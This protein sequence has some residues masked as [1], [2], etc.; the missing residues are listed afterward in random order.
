MSAFYDK[1]DEGP[2]AFYYILLK[3]NEKFYNLIS[4]MK[5][6]NIIYIVDNFILIK[7]DNLFDLVGNEYYIEYFPVNSK[8]GEILNPL[9]ENKLISYINIITNNLKKRQN[10]LFTTDIDNSYTVTHFDKFEKQIHFSKTYDLGL[11]RL[12]AEI[13]KNKLKLSSNKNILLEANGICREIL[14][15]EK[16]IIL[17]KLFIQEQIVGEAYRQ[18]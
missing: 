8:I 1:N 15:H 2:E 11:I 14:F 16:N 10:Q 7:K 6:F 18:V 13:K 4:K 17:N 3:L 5:L 12:N 9:S